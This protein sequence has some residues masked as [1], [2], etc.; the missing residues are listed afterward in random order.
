MQ[1]AVPGPTTEEKVSLSVSPVYSVSLG[2]GIM[3]SDGVPK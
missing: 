2:A 3:P 1:M